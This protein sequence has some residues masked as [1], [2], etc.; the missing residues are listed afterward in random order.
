V[1]ED[2]NVAQRKDRE[3]GTLGRFDHCT[4]RNQTLRMEPA[5]RSLST[6]PDA[7]ANSRPPGPT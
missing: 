7:A 3:Q 4:Y 5:H 2:D 1:R 6:W